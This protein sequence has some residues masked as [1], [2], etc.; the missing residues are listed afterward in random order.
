MVD[1]VL[2]VAKMPPKLMEFVQ[3]ETPDA[4]AAGNSGIGDGR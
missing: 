4:V 1:W 2:P 3:N